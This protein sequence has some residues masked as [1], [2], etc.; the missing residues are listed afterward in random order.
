MSWTKQQIVEAAYAELGYAHS[1]FDLGATQ[2]QVGLRKLDVMIAAWNSLG[3]RVGWP[4]PSSPELSTL[5]T[6][7]GAPDA[8]TEAIILN[9][10]QR[11]A[12]TIGKTCARETVVNAQQA[13]QALLAHAIAQPPERQY[14]VD[15]PMGAGNKPWRNDSEYFTPE[16][17]PV[18]AGD[19]GDLGFR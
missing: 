15:L 2:L 12:P 4:M 14:P 5:T 3:I 7:T 1:A 10:A 16:T 17:E 13:Y 6:E 9:L 19:D 11:I 8:A 18:L